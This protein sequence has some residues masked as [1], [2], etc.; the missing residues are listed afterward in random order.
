MKKFEN[1]LIV[2]DLDGTFLSSNSMPVEGNLGAI[3]YF[4]QNGGHFTVASGRVFEHIIGSIPN[5]HEL[6]NVPIITCNG[7]CLYD[8]KT[9][10]AIEKYPID[11]ELVRG[12]FE[13]VKKDF[14]EVGMR[15][16]AHEYC[17][18]F[19]PEGLN[20]T[21]L[22]GDYARYKNMHC[23]V[24]PFEEWSK[25][26][27][28]KVV[29]RGD[30][31]VTDRLLCRLEKEFGECITAR[32]S[33]ETVVD[34]QAGGINKGRA[35]KAL[36]EGYLPKGTFVYACGDYINDTDML[37]AAD[38]SVCPSGAHEYIKSISDLCLCSNDEGLIG[39]LVEYL[40]RTV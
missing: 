12:I 29:L 5:I 27:I 40:D 4:K 9:D 31:D 1:I 30:G 18:M 33:W 22:A 14:P 2:T 28:L 19:M 10:M 16:G 25:M 34:V 17:F 8:T 7:A 20:N 36:T 21:Y 39:A 3:E 38:V 23:H 35:L 24:L 6:V 13:L 32:K 37:L 11:F 26:P 15:A